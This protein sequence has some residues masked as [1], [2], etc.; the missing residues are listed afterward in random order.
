MNRNITISIRN[1]IKESYGFVANPRY[2]PAHNATMILRSMPSWHYFSRPSNMEMH[3]LTTKDTHIPKTLTTIIGLGLKFIPTPRRPNRNPISS[4]ARFRKDLLTKVYFSGRPIPEEK[5][6]NVKMPVTSDWEPKPWD[7]P[8]TI[9]DRLAN[10]RRHIRRSMKT[11]RPKTT[12]LLPFQTRAL[13]NLAQRTDVLVV[14]CDKNLGP[15]L[16]NT[17]TY[18]DRAFE[19]HLACPITYKEFTE[20]EADAHMRKV[21]QEINLWLM[22]YRTSTKKRQG[23]DKKELSFLNANFDPEHAQLPVFYLTLKVHKTPWTT[24]PI[25]SCSGSLL[26]H[27]GIWVD[28]HLQKI[29]ITQK[30]YT[31]NSRE[32]KDNIIQLSPLPPGARLFTADATS[33]YTNINT[34]MAIIEIAQYLHQHSNRF[35]TIP[36]DALISALSIVMRNNVFRFGDTFWHQLQGTA[37]GT[38]PAPTYANLFFAIHENRI[39]RKYS[40]NLLIHKRYID[41][42]FGIWIPSDDKVKDEEQWK[43]YVRDID[44][45]HGLKWLFSPRCN[46]VDFL[47]ITI[48]IKENNVLHTT[49]FEKSL[50]LYL[51][52]PPHSAHPPGVLTGLVIGNCHRIHTLC[53]DESDRTSN[54][55]NFLRRL[56]ARGYP[57]HTLLPLFHRAHLLASSQAADELCTTVDDNKKRIF[58]HLEFHP[59]SPRSPELQTIWRNTVLQPPSME[60]LSLVRN[61]HDREVEIRQMTVAYSRPRNLGNLLS[62]RNL[63]LSTGLPVSSYRK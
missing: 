3:D 54:L 41:D 24:R 28:S 53:S 14:S 19:D 43:K 47:D 21:A 5:K 30:T 16:I 13:A 18:V 7:I 44:T 57:L 10:F 27:L 12:N 49:L 62:P 17:T 38:P 4:F 48:S 59:D 6:Y 25:V 31:K 42:I 1:K 9:H 55:R 23:I 37:M 58:F 52:I 60:H 50:N 39:L 8:E 63:H 29:A 26:Y 22:K 2:S 46:K 36:A 15:A 51:Y 45:Y 61:N 35:P 33:M 32:L 20:E 40:K 11:K 34:N 56:R